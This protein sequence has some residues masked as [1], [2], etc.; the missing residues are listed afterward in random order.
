M[1]VR[2]RLITP[3]GVEPVTVAELKAQARGVDHDEE[4]GLL[5][6]MITVA[7]ELAE[8][9]TGRAL[10]TQTWQQTS[11]P[12][13]GWVELRKWP[14][15]EVISVNVDAGPLAGDTWQAFLGDSAGVQVRDAIGHVSVEYIAG[16][17]DTAD[18]VPAA[19]RQ[20]I[21]I[22][23]ATMYEHREAEVVGGSVSS[24]GYVDGLLDPYCIAIA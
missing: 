10:I 9:R 1:T 16:Y 5:Q 14:A 20:W 24:L 19:I 2:S 11:R 15:I 13:N 7:R 21:L 23:A 8:Q 3:P 4:D 17:G 6:Q 18:P 12:R 22:A